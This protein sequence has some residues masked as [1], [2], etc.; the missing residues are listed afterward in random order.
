MCFFEDIVQI[1]NDDSDKKALISERNPQLSD[2][3]DFLRMLTLF[4]QPLSDSD[5]TSPYWS[6][7]TSFV[8]CLIQLEPG[9]S[10]QHHVKFESKRDF[11]DFTTTLP[12]LQGGLISKE[13]AHLIK[14]DF[15]YYLAKTVTPKDW[16]DVHKLVEMTARICP[17]QKG[18]LVYIKKHP[19]KFTTNIGFEEYIR[20]CQMSTEL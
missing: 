6:D 4:Q 7:L 12:L 15:L 20:S 2:V 18:F 14:W 1:R 16:A 13:N 10:T 3:Y 17:N 9:L 8:Q 5:D 11:V 19:P